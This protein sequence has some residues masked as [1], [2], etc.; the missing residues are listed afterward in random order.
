MLAIELVE[1]SFGSLNTFM[2]YVRLHNSFGN[3]TVDEFMLA[4]YLETDSKGETIF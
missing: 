1:S 3:I 4:N 2:I